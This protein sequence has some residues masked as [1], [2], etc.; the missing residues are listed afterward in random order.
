[1]TIKVGDKVRIKT[2][3]ELLAEGWTLDNS[4]DKTLFIKDINDARYVFHIGWKDKFPATVINKTKN[5]HDV[6]CGLDNGL[7]LFED[8]LIKLPQTLDEY[9]CS[10]PL[11]KRARWFVSLIKEENR[12]GAYW[13][14]S[15]IVEKQYRFYGEALQATIDALKQPKEN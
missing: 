14:K 7:Y 12:A 9:I 13:Y 3:E 10:L 1:M 15:S 6:V 8:Y 2:E 5:R 4:A 11:E